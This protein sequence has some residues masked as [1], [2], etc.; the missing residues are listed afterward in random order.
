MSVTYAVGDIH[1]RSDLLDLLHEHIREHH[2]LLHA[3][4]PGHIVYIGDYIDGGFDAPGVIDRLMAGLEGFTS[5]CLMGN[6]EAMM[7]DCLDTDN[8]RPWFDWLSN[9]GDQTL[10]SLGVAFTTGAYDPSRL[11]DA[12][13]KARIA[14]L[15]ARPLTH[16][17]GAYLFVHAGIAPGVPLDEQNPQDLLWIRHRFLSSEADHGAI[18]VH[19]HTVSDDPQLRPNRIGIDTGATSHGCLTAAVL[20]GNAKPIFLQARGQPGHAP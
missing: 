16:R 6:H 14:W 5:T 13:G 10:E 9:G 7:L 8:W 15:K 1:G 11:R 18:V 20:A 3:G 2:G 17:I 4:N 12:L 19:G